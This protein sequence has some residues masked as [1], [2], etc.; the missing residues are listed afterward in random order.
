MSASPRSIRRLVLVTVAGGLWLGASAGAA[1]A[2]VSIRGDDVVAG[3]STVLTLSVPHG[4]EG[5]A[6]TRLAVQIPAGVDDVAPTVE[7][8]WTVRK[9]LV[10]LPKPITLADGDR[11]TERVDQVVYTARTPLPDGFRARFELQVEIPADAAGTTL[12]FPTVQTCGEDQVAWTQ[13]PAEGQDPEE[14][15]SPAPT[16]VVAAGAVTATPGPS[17]VDQVLT[18][19]APPAVG[20]GRGWG[21]AGFVAGL[22]GLAT[23]SLALLRGGRRSA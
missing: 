2:H 13:V 1:S 10:H 18:S 9:T 3:S 8:G 21:L 22:G 15:E 4:C 7:P 12:R 19:P 14:L 6:T 23:G 17:A 11:V 16:L 20:S 5:A